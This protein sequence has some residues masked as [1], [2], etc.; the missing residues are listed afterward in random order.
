MK[1]AVPNS[2]AVFDRPLQ[3]HQR[4]A[5]GRAIAIPFLSLSKVAEFGENDYSYRFGHDGILNRY[6]T[7]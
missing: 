2:L 1:G 4:S 6:Y 7:F 3:A 5:W